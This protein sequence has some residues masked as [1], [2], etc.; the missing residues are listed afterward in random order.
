MVLVYRVFEKARTG[1]KTSS[2]YV[3]AFHLF[4]FR[5]STIR[6]LSSLS[7]SSVF[8]PRSLSDSGSVV[9]RDR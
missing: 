5:Y 9:S 3:V 6:T 7:L 2:D 8:Q 4:L 1:L